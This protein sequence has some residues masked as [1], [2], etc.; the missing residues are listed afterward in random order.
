[1]PSYLIPE[2]KRWKLA[3]SADRSRTPLSWR[4]ECARRARADRRGQ[5]VA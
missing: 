3:L 1:V 5:V 2:L 4:A